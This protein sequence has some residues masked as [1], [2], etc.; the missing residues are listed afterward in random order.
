[1]E[2]NDVELVASLTADQPSENDARSAASGLNTLL[3]I[4]TPLAKGDDQV[5]LSKAQTAAQG[6]TFILNFKLPKKDVQD[7]ILRKL[8]ELKA[9]EGK[10]N[11]SAQVVSKDNT[12]TK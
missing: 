7:M 10:P 3:S 8:A 1:V 12:A 5:F 9:S 11:G 4:A 6:K 2:Q